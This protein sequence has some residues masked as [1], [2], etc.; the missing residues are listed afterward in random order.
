[1]GGRAQGGS[2]DWF[3]R[4]IGAAHWGRG[5]ELLDAQRMP[6]LIPPPHSP[7]PSDGSL[8][9]EDDLDLETMIQEGVSQYA[10]HD[11]TRVL[12]VFVI[13]LTVSVDGCVGVA[14]GGGAI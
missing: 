1:M 4:V 6:L 2:T 10:R 12:P 13:T 9:L 5:E 8:Y 3:G 14:H 7:H 11:G